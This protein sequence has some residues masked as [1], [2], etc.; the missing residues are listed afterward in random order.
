VTAALLASPPVAARDH[1]GSA[2]A[3][4]RRR[5][6]RGGW[7]VAL[8]IA[9]FAA[10]L[11][12][13]SP[14]V[15]VQP[16]E[17]VAGLGQQIAYALRGHNDGIAVPLRET[18]GLFYLERAL[19]PALGIPTLLAAVAGAAVLL[20]RD[21]R[22]AGLLVAA[23]AGFVAVMEV[24]PAKPYPFFA[25]Y[26]LPAVPPIVV[27]AGIVCARLGSVATHGRAPAAFR[28]GAIVVL[29]IVFMAPALRT[30]R[31]VRAMYPDTRDVARVWLRANLPPRVR[32]LTTSYGPLLPGA[33]ALDRASLA[34]AT[35]M[36]RGGEAPWLVL[37]DLAV[38]RYLEHPEGNPE[39]FELYDG[40][41]R[42]GIEVQRFASHGPRFGFYNPTLRVY[43]LNPAHGS[44][45]RGIPDEASP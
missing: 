42:D 13:G 20:R 45:T 31:F 28:I 11:L 12:V 26:V 33:R 10:G 23:G 37:S 36:S 29:A 22:L 5:W 14:S 30:A 35:A 15:L 43:Q 34:R 38:D 16:W 32:L 19:V 2:F 17:I 1:N 27:L 6:R 9:G 41:A 7:L 4:D 8:T 44:A 40:V 39:R 24:F 3:H 21:W 25:R 18:L